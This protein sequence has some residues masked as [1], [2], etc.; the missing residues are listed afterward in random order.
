MT[1]VLG[2]KGQYRSYILYNLFKR[3]SLPL[4]NSLSLSGCVYTSKWCENVNQVQ[5]KIFNNNMASLED[6]ELLESNSSK[7][8]VCTTKKRD[9][10]RI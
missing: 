3:L 4:P 2:G 1:I 10:G 9:A 5:T 8:I 6:L 7:C